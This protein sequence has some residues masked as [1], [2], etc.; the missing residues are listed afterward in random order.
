MA[1]G[2]KA[3]GNVIKRVFS[4]VVA[5]KH[6]VGIVEKLTV[7]SAVVLCSLIQLAKIF[8][9]LL[10]SEVRSDIKPK[11]LEPGDNSTNCFLERVHRV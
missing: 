10:D 3:S 1:Q 6:S 2:L 4:N 8:F 7:D 11:R 5:I 9:Q